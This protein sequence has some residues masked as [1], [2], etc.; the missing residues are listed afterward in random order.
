[1]ALK[2]ILK[3]HEQV[4]IGGAVIKNGNGRSELFIENNVP[5]LRQKDILNVQDA[6][7]PCKRVYLSIQLMYV[8]E[9]NLAEY[10]KIYWDLVRDIV[11]AS[12]TVMN[13]LDQISENILCNRY[14]QA[15]KLARRLIDYEQVLLQEAQESCSVVKRT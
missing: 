11:R 5:I 10:H 7:S 9:N 6:D 3:P 2:L 4:I 12:P 1:M 15:L 14:Y 8:D 13:L